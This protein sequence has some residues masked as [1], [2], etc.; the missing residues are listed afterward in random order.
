MTLL[1]FHLVINAFAT[2]AQLSVLFWVGNCGSTG[3]VC[4]RLLTRARIPCFSMF[5]G[6]IVLRHTVDLG[7]N[8]F[9]EI[10]CRDASLGARDGRYLVESK[11][12]HSLATLF[13]MKVVELCPS[14]GI[15]FLRFHRC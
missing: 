13:R 3:V 14:R 6:R 11:F 15:S 7:L 4:P 10:R 12:S 9:I 5:L 2:C 8:V 1:L